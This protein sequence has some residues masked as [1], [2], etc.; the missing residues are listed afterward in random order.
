MESSRNGLKMMITRQGEAEIGVLH[1]GDGEMRA[2]EVE[3]EDECWRR[4]GGRRRNM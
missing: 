1:N 3:M 4:E 2:K